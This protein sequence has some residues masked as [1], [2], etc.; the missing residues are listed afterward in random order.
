M[1]VYNLIIYNNLYGTRLMNTNIIC[2]KSIA[3]SLFVCKTSNVYKKRKL[4]LSI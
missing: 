4:K 2:E 3:I 1:H